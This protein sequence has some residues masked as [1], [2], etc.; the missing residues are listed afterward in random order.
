MS[1]TLLL[2]AIAYFFCTTTVHSQSTIDSLLVEELEQ[3][4]KIDQFAA[5]NAQPPEGYKQLS[6]EQWEAKKDSIY[7]ANQKRAAEILDEFGFP[8]Y[9][10]V[11]QKGSTNFW[12]TVQHA[13]F[14]PVFQQKVLEVMYHEVKKDNASN[15]LYALLTDRVNKNTGKLLVYGT[16]VDYNFFTGKAYPLPTIDPDN[17]N[18]RRAEVGLE[19]IE[20]YLADMTNTFLERSPTV[21]GL[22]IPGLIVILAK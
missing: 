8:G 19:P 12:A 11:G 9:D 5:V 22:T 2:L 6:Q 4:G 14:D 7:R 13:D 20:A 15:R 18:Q 17:L 3:L 1:K 21:L 16:Q 10:L